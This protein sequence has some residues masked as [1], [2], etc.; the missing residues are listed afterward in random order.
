[1]RLPYCPRCARSMAPSAIH[2]RQCAACDSEHHWNV[3]GFARVGPYESSLRELLL[4]LKF[5][6]NERVA[7]WLS[8]ALTQ[9]IKSQPWA[10]EIE[11]IAAPPMHLLRRL[12]RPCDHARVLA[13]GVCRRL[14]IPVTRA[15]F[16]TRYTPS[17]INAPSRHARFESIKGCFDA[18]PSADVRGRVVLIVD[19]IVVSGATIGEVAKAL[20]RA[21]AK[22]VYGA[23]VARSLGPRDFQAQT[24]ALSQT[25]P[26]SE[27]PPQTI[28]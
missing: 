26:A 9:A 13:E 28:G 21:G 3:R 20:R 17:L 15:V 2:G 14:R 1:M 7:D 16:R 25:I 23:V 19:N 4:S 6:G 12:Q 10:G 27:D 11:T 8:E 18:K 5:G 24:A 22:V